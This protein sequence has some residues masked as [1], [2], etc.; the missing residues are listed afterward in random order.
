MGQFLWVRKKRGKFLWVRKKRGQFPWVRIGQVN[1]IIILLIYG[2]EFITNSIAIEYMYWHHAVYLV[3]FKKHYAWRRQ[4][5]NWYVSVSFDHGRIAWQ[6]GITQ[7][8]VVTQQLGRYLLP[9]PILFCS[10]APPQPPTVDSPY[11]AHALAELSWL[12]GW[13]CCRAQNCTESA[14]IYDVP[15]LARRLRLRL[16]RRLILEL[17]V[18]GWQQQQ[19]R[20][21]TQPAAAA[22]AAAA[23]TERPWQRRSAEYWFSSPSL[24]SSDWPAAAV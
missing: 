17:N 14:K 4:V 15:P 16:W 6:W 21:A 2:H 19:Q 20:E 5:C 23:A 24:A 7:T 22:A 11:T 10:F 12:P 8:Y 3:V 13:R 9:V 1:S 18:S